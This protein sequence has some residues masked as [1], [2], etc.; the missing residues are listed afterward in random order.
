MMVSLHQ[1]ERVGATSGLRDE[2]SKPT[3]AIAERV[4]GSGEPHSASAA[5]QA[6]AADRSSE[7]HAGGYRE[8]AR[9]QGVGASRVRGETRHDSGVVPTTD[10]AEV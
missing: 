7:I 10:R 1:D 8:T 4:L 5:A 9:P 3:G 2:A 6:T